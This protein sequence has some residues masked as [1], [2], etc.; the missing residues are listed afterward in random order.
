MNIDLLKKEVLLSE[1]LKLK[2]YK[3]T[4][5]KL[6]IGIGRNLTDK[7][8]STEEC[9]YLF[10]NDIKDAIK[11]AQSFDWFASLNDVRQN[12]IVEMVFNMGKGG[13]SKFGEFIKAIKQEDWQKA[14]AEMLDSEWA[15][16]V[17]G[18]AIGLAYMF[19]KG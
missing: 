16:E 11:E 8:L 1:G 12:V 4:K 2:P 5:G 17:K 6:T 18:R 14:K 7:G 13:V 15:R 9:L 3:D 19:E 10:Q